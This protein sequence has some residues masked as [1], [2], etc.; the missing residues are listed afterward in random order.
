MATTLTSDLLATKAKLFRGFSDPSRLSILEA[1]RGG[2]LS[3][4]QIVD[5]TGLSQPNTSNHLACLLDCGLVRR[6][7]C[8]RFA[9]YEVSDSRVGELL[10]RAEDLL[11]DVAR[12]VE[13]C[14]RYAE[15]EERV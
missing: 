11:M 9:H 7:Q 2:P 4:S 1:L 12:G 15:P 6:E 13:V 5:A 3:V 10:E 8:G 14:G